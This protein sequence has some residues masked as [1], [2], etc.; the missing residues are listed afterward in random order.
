LTTLLLLAVEAAAGRLGLVVVEAL[1]GPVVIEQEQVLRLVQV[2]NT[3]L[4]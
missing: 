2:L 1:V 3:Q 4:R